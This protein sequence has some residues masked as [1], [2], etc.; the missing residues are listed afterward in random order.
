MEKG[1]Q[2]RTVEDTYLQDDA[3]EATAGCQYFAKDFHPG[4]Q[5]RLILFLLQTILNPQSHSLLHNVE[6]VI[7]KH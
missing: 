4:A 6:S 5:R 1:L 7:G 2:E 3:A